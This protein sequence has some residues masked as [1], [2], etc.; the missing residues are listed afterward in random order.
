SASVQWVL[1]KI[2]RRVLAYRP[3]LGGV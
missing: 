3:T 1:I 2:E